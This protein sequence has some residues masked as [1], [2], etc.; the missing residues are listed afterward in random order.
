VLFRS[1]IIHTAAGSQL[2]PRISVKNDR[3]KTVKLPDS[4]TFARYSLP[5]GS[6][7]SVNEGDT[8]QPGSIVGK[9]PRET[10]KTKDIT[11]GLPRVAELFE[12]RKPKDPA[13]ISKIDGKISFGKELKG[14]RRIIVTP[15]YGEPQEYL[16]PKSKHII[17]HEGDYVQ[18]GE[19]LMEGTIVPNDILSV[20]GVKELAK[21]LVNE[22]QEVYRLQGV[23]INDKHIEVIVRQ[24]LKRVMIT[25]SGDS[26]FMI[27][28][29]VEWWKFEEERDML[30]MQ[31]KKPPVA[32]PLLLGVTKA[33]LSTESF[34]SAASFQETTKVLT[35]A[36][37]AGRID[38]LAGLKEN[39]IMGRLISAGTGLKGNQ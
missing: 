19:A 4:E 17:V 5:V 34:I 3:G 6:I 7:I 21:F 26:R 39:V 35:N 27:G 10:T 16:V 29:Q 14:K 36:A 30:M 38:E 23:K 12:V 1:V 8:I 11:G 24:M 22:I 25:A 13:I 31:G 15:E 9:I 37:V 28:E 2:N 20:L 32:E 18:A 33:S